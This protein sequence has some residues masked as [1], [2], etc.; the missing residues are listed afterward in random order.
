MRTPT[1][2]GCAL[3][4]SSDAPGTVIASISSSDAT[5]STKPT[6]A[7]TTAFAA[8]TRWT[9]G[10]TSNV[11]V[12]VPCVA[13]PAMI[14]IP[15]ISANKTDSAAICATA[16]SSDAESIVPSEADTEIA[17]IEH[18]PRF[19]SAIQRTCGPSGS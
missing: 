15:P 1:S 9:H 6:A 12:I 10:V 5:A 8:R 18:K 3:S 19:A 14:T 2:T 4:T 11:C 7:A 16:R 13:S 17:V